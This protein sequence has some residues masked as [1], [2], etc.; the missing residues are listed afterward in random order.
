MYKWEWN[1]QTTELFNKA[2]EDMWDNPQVL[3]NACGMNLGHS[4]IHVQDPNRNNFERIIKNGNSGECFFA[5]AKEA[6]DRIINAIYSVKEDIIDWMQ[7]S[8]ILKNNRVRYI[9]ADKNTFKLIINFEESIGVEYM[10]QQSYIDKNCNIQTLPYTDGNIHKV[11]CNHIQ[12]ILHA[13]AD[14]NN[15]RYS[16]FG[17]VLETAFPINLDRTS[18]DI[19]IITRRDAIKTIP[20]MT[21]IENT[22]FV[23]KGEIAKNHHMDINLQNSS[24]ENQNQVI[25]FDLKNNKGNLQYTAYL[26]PDSVNY[27]KYNNNLR[28]RIP[29]EMVTDKSFS[30]IINQ[31]INYYTS[32]AEEKINNIRRMQNE[33]PSHFDTIDLDKL[34]KRARTRYRKTGRTKYKIK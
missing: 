7:G 29:P 27:Y 20:N 22:F 17:F 18:K 10:T 9:C 24:Q 11:N 23:F 14:H 13:D 33:I 31:A 30:D 32:I 12:I 26:S 6:N 3:S 8:D 2:M 34:I 28:K 25:K 21:S 4:N 15:P 1:D 5:N 19:D 16:Q